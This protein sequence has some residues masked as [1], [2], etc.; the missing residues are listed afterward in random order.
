MINPEIEPLLS[1]TQA[2][3]RCPAI[4]GKR[5]HPSTVFR[6]IRRGVRGG[7]RLE[8]VMVGRRLCTTEAALNRFFHA[9]A[10]AASDAL[11]VEKPVQRRAVAAKP[12]SERQRQRDIDRAAADLDAAGIGS[13]DTSR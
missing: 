7:V 2:A 11:A 1:L 6:W 12:R 9:A 13:S 5:V 10:Q 8:S 3:H 4:D